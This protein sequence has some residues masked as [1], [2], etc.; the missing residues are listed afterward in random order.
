MLGAGL[1]L[2]GLTL[3]LFFKNNV[4]PLATTLAAALSLSGGCLLG[5]A[6]HRLGRLGARPKSERSPEP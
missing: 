2:F 1:L 4:A 3:S 6:T 5:L